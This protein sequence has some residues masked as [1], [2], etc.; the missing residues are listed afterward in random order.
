[1]CLWLGQMAT[2]Q[3]EEFLVPLCSKPL[4]HWFAIQ[5]PPAISS[6]CRYRTRTAP[7]LLPKRAPASGMRAT[8]RHVP[9]AANTSRRIFSVLPSGCGAERGREW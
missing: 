6:T 4:A 5:A 3:V 7:P 9:P 1:M 8:S 2:L